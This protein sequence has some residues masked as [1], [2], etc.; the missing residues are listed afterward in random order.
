MA[1]NDTLEHAYDTVDSTRESIITKK[2]ALD[3]M[4]SLLVCD[5]GVKLEGEFVG[6]FMNGICES[7]DHDIERLEQLQVEIR[8]IREVLA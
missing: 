5:T 3:N 6:T 2:R 7:L 8:Q 1:I 4:N